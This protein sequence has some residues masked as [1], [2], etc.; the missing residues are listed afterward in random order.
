METNIKIS[1]I[2]I[3][4]SIVLLFLFND[5][6]VKKGLII[7]EERKHQGIKQKRTVLKKYFIFKLFLLI[8]IFEGNKVKRYIY[9]RKLK[10]GKKYLK[11]NSKVK[12]ILKTTK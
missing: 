5:F 7:F 1:I 8:T 9:F 2:L 12:T 4:V 11:I 10:H 3:I 6:F